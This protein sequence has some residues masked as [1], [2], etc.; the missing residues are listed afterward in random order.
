MTSGL[1]GSKMAEESQAPRVKKAEGV[2][3]AAFVLGL[4]SLLGGLTSLPAII[5]AIIALSR[6]TSR[7]DLAVSGIVFALVLPAMLLP[8]YLDIISARGHAELRRTMNCQANLT[9]LG[10]AVGIY[11]ALNNEAYPTSLATLRKADA[12]LQEFHCFWSRVPGDSYFYLAPSGRPVDVAPQTIIA[13]DL[14]TAH[15]NG[16]RSILCADTTISN[17]RTDADFKQLLQKPCNAAFA[18]ALREAERP[19]QRP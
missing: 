12:Y 13:C 16:G 19:S 15:P 6:R 7:R 1:K 14:L 9:M 18:A 5:C 11:Q 4:C 17:V 3:L 8:S 10:K 2:A